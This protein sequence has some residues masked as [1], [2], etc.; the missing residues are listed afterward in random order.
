MTDC[1]NHDDDGADCGTPFVTERKSSETTVEAILR[2]VAT[3]TGV[4]ETELDPLYDAVAVE[5][6]TALVDHGDRPIRVTFGYEGHTVVVDGDGSIR[7]VDDPPR[8]PR[9]GSD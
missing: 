3:I 6:L 1:Q 7:I 5:A 2:G 4:D 8:N 9:A